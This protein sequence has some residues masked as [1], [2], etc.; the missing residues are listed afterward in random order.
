MQWSDVVNAM[1]SGFDTVMF[2]VTK[3]LDLFT[4][5]FSEII[6]SDV[7]VTSWVTSL[8]QFILD[9]FGIDF[10]SL[11]PLDFALGSV[12]PIVIVFTIYRYVKQ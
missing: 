2:W 7:G 1:S 3:L 10:L 12:I 4:S 8:I 11:T 5:P 6:D 9:L